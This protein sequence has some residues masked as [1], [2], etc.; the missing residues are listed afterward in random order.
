VGF[1]GAFA[2]GVAILLLLALASPLAAQE[3]RWDQ[4][5][6]QATELREQGKDAEA[7]RVAEEAVQVAEATFG[8]DHQN[9]ALS[10]NTLGLMYDEQGKY[11]EAELLFKRSLAIR[12]KALGP[13]DLDIA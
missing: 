4:L 10:L 5:T 7:I 2:R 8:A 12:E 13:N 11:A 1:S 6:E 9:L 3:A